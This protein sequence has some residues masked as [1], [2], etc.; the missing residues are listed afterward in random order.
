GGDATLDSYV[1]HGRDPMDP[2]HLAWL[3][4]L[5]LIHTAA[6]ISTV[7]VHAGVS[8]AHYPRETAETYLWTRAA[9]FF[10]PDRWVSPALRDM[11]VVHGHTVSLGGPDIAGGGRRINVDTG[12]VFGGALTAAILVPGEAARFLSV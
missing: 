3:E 12:A 8:A 2:G 7:F 1:A 5:P 11:T 10:D 4:R 6:D 9:T